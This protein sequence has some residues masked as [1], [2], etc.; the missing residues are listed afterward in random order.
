MEQS[1]FESLKVAF[2]TAPIL[3]M[4]NM[5]AAFWVEID[6]SDF[7]VEAVLLQVAEDG[8]WQPVV[9]FLK[10]MQPAERN[11]DVHNKELLLVVQTLEVWRP[12]LEGNSFPVEIFSDHWNLEFFMMA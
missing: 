6:A 7:V 9:S 1:A 10:A 12:Y 3:V 5:E 8:E 11:Y 2:A 4:P